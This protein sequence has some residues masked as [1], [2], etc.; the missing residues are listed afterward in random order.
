MVR[1]LSY[2]LRRVY[3]FSL[4]LQT[5]NVHV[6]VFLL[7]AI[8]GDAVDD[9]KVEPNN[10]RMNEVFPSST[11]TLLFTSNKASLAFVF[12]VMSTSLCYICLLLALFDLGQSS[13]RDN[14][15]SE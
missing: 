15:F 11:Y 9:E 12:A 7:S 10:V 14:I 5:I 3:C 6:F 8:S 4:S 1:T 2:A 13:T